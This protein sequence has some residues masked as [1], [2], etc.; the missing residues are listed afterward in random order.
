MLH[1]KSSPPSPATAHESL[2]TTIMCDG[3]LLAEQ[4]IPGAWPCTAATAS[5]ELETTL[6]LQAR[7]CT[8][9]HIPAG[10]ATTGGEGY[11]PGKRGVGGGLKKP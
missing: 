11:V 7:N 3:R 1:L 2:P 4:E 10:R 5:R 6:P 9:V 8:W